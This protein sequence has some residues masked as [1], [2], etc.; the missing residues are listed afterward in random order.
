MLEHYEITAFDADFT[1]TFYSIG[2]KGK[3]L[4]IV[5]FLSVNDTNDYFQFGFGD[6]DETR[7]L[8]DDKIVSNNGDTAMIL[9]TL[10]T[11]IENFTTKFPNAW[12]YA[13]GNTEVKTRFYKIALSQNLTLIQQD[14]LL[15]GRISG[16]WKPFAPNQPYTDF[17]LKR[18]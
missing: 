1:Y 18:K 8:I 6:Y 10:G 4:K 16:L 14:Y 7:G 11:I 9:T 13:K 15:F 17:L 3:I 12:I 2:K 5:R